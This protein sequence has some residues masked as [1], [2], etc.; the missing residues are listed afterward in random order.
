[1]SRSVS[2]SYGIPLCHQFWISIKP[3]YI[4]PSLFYLLMTK[5]VCNWY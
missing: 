2:I 5:S 4:K 3:I 1:M